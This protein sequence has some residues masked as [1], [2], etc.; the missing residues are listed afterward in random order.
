MAAASADVADVVMP[1]H[2]DAAAMMA[3]VA[4]MADHADLGERLARLDL[5]DLVHADRL[6]GCLRL[7]RRGERAGCNEGRKGGGGNEQLAHCILLKGMSSWSI[8]TRSAPFITGR[9]RTLA[10]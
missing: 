2:H 5:D 4:A 3:P 9:R 10:E 1:L 7:R 6:H 8:Q